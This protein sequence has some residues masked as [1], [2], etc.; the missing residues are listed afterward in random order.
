[1]RVRRM[2]SMGSGYGPNP[3]DDSA[4][5][6]NPNSYITNLADCMLVMAC[7][8]MVALISAWNVTLPNVS[9]VYQT[10][11]M[12][13]VEDLEELEGEVQSGGDTYTEL[14][15]VYQDP[16]TGQMYM[17]QKDDGGGSGSGAQ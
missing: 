2:Q 4:E 7:G 8:L 12:R 3:Y 6:V 16:Q 14:G 11:E 17:I 9:E 15:K 13:E 10:E 1:M 5:D